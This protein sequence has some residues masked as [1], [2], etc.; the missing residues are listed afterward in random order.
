MGTF[1]ISS[2]IYADI[3]I[4]FGAFIYLFRKKK[5][6]G[7]QLG[8]NIS[9]V[10]GGIAA[11]LSGILLILQFPFHFTPITIISTV[12]GVVVGASFGL[13]FDYQTFITGLT[14]GMVVGLMAPMIGMVLEVPVQFLWFVHGLFFVCLLSIM[15]SI[16]RS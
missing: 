7:F 3:C 13:L 9:Q 14:N 1:T 15:M 5:L 16:Q 12:I 10:M 2:L 8:M 6:I 11:L 4:Y